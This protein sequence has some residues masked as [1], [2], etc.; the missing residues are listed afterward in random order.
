V[1]QVAGERA[2]DAMS[3]DLDILSNLQKELAGDFLQEN[4]K[5][6][7]R[8]YTMRL[9][10]EKENGWTFRFFKAGNEL[11]LAIAVRSAQLAI[12]IRAIDGVS[13]IDCTQSRLNALSIPE[14]NDLSDRNDGNPDFV[15]S[16]LF[17]QFIMDLS[18]EYVGEL[19]E[20]WTKLQ[21]KQQ[22]AQEALKKSSGEDSETVEKKNSTEPSPD[23]EE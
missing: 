6:R 16:E 12:G 11:S 23:G 14:R 19:H 15:A 3:T 4:V 21:L 9:L 20:T 17:M 13:L 2:I 5:V 8:T 1:T 22:E 10:T 18:P 7:G